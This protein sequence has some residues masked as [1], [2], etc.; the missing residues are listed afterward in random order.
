[1]SSIYH[2]IKGPGSGKGT[3]CEKIVAKYGYTHLSSGDLLRNEVKSGSELG[4]QMNELMQKGILVPNEL[5]L[6]MLKEAILAKV[7]SSKGFLIDG[8][9][10]EVNQGLSFESEVSFILL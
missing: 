10:R 1:M 6:D 4:K 7:D 3:Q 2:Y 5:V 8:Y 9:P